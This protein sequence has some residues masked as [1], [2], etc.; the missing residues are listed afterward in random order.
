M[1]KKSMVKIQQKMYFF[2]VKYVTKNVGDNT[3]VNVL[4][5]NLYY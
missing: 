4:Y 5:A 2:Y 3:F 1:L